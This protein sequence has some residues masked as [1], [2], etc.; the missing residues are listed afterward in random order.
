MLD[1]GIHFLRAN[2]GNNSTRYN[3]RHKMTVHPD[4]FN[5]VY[6]HDWDITAKKVLDKM[7]GVDAMYAF[8]LT[9]Y[10]AS[11]TEMQKIV[12]AN[13]R[14]IATKNGISR[15]EQSFMESAFAS[16]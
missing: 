2:N 6:A 8:Q 10:A 15:N 13:W 11:S 14:K 1:A 4:W 7:P 12:C 9:G 5:N 16:R 3:W